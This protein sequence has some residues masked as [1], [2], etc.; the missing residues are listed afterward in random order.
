MPKGVL[1]QQPRRVPTAGCRREWFLQ[2][3]LGHKF[4][5][6]ADSLVSRHTLIGTQPAARPCLTNNTTAIGYLVF[7]H[8]LGADT[9]SIS[10]LQYAVGRNS[11][12]QLLLHLHPAPGG[13]VSSTAGCGSQRQ[14]RA[15]RP[16]RAASFLFLGKLFFK[17]NDPPMRKATISNQF[18]HFQRFDGWHSGAHPTRTTPSGK[19]RGTFIIWRNAHRRWN[20][21]PTRSRTHAGS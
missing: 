16:P 10:V 11:L 1:A 21:K 3:F 13:L 20:T 8:G 15:R 19:K 7:M 12:T 4:E 5:H 6:Q 17:I 18:C 9:A 14:C 2:A